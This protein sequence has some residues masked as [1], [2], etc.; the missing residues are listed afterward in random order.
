MR[1]H[2]VKVCLLF[3]SSPIFVLGQTVKGNY[4]P[5]SLKDLS[6][7]Q[8]S[9]SNWSVQ[10][11]VVIHPTGLT[12]TKMLAGEGVLIGNAGSAI[13]TK[14]KA[15]DLRLFLEFMVSPGAEGS[16]VLPGGQKVR[17][18]DSSKQ[19]MANALTSGYIGQFPTQNASK[20]PGLWQTLELAYDASVPHIP[21]SARLNSLALNGVTILETIYL[22]NSKPANEGQ[23]LSLEVTKGTIAFRNIGYQLL[24]NSKPLTLNNLTYKVYSDKWDSKEYSKLD[25]EGQ[26]GILTQ[27]V[28][29]GMREFHLVYEGDI[30]V[31][32]AGDYLFTTI[33]SGPVLTL[34][35]DGKNV[36]TNGESTSQESHTG[37][38]NLTQGKHPF[39]LY[40]SRFPWR[41]P[42]LG[43]RVEKSGVRPYDLHVL[44]SLPEPEPKPYISVT[45]DMRPEMVRSFVLIPGEKYKRTHCISVGSPDGWNYTVDLNRGALLQAWRGQFADVTEMWY[46]RGEPQI[47]A[48]AGLNVHISGRSSF[49]ALENDKTAWP[50]SSNINFLGYKIQ[51]QG[52]PVFRYAV[53]GTT[54]TD[55]M[56]S[57][58]NTF[59][60]TVKV[61]GAATS[62]LYSLLAS[63]KRIVEIE[64]G[65]YQVDDRFYVMVDK[66]AKPLIRPSGETSELVLPISGTTSY[67]MFW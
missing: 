59:T 62:P 24:A 50:D 13:T 46:E 25:H 12:K 15:S 42:A 39:K 52:Y 1:R 6:S 57:A 38:V 29:N 22:P 54:I 41:Q 55:E 18:S 53:G 47:L 67:S 10:G 11:N 56:V 28:T 58:G 20:S 37:S 32:E 4:S 64:K 63:G 17:L 26:S 7:F 8:S 23:S 34:D 30:N 14:L 27:E 19:K 3:L 45:P 2:I 43:L 16:V 36:L 48:P 9:S 33:Y 60:R 31:S 40:Y 44:S 51:A 21:N 49:A 35:V 66:K 65:L 5:L 61:D